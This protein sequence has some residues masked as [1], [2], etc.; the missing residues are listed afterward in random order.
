MQLPRLAFAQDNAV[1]SRKGAVSLAVSV[2]VWS[3]QV[4]DVSPPNH[5]PPVNRG[6]SRA[7]DSA[8]LSFQLGCCLMDVDKRFPPSPRLH[9]IP[10]VVTLWEYVRGHGD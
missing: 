4:G 3:T 8:A 2:F 10:L 7:G 5:S 9:S 6:G 1:S